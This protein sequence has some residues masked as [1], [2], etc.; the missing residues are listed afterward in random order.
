MDSDEYQLIVSCQQ[1]NAEAFG[2]IYE[3]Y[4]ESIYRFIYFKTMHTET[5]EDLTSQTFMKALEKLGTFTEQRGSFKNWLYTIARN[6]VIDH[7]RKLHWQQPVTDIWEVPNG[8]DIELAC[9]QRELLRQLETYMTHLSPRQREI[10]SWRMW[11]NLS[12]REIAALTGQSEGSCKMI[13]SR[14]LAVLRRGLNIGPQIF[15]LIFFFHLCNI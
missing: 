2:K 4:V 10:V 15:L 9:D 11:D 14:A 13:F 7:F 5:A 3:R 8:Q 12:Y 1:G 6:T